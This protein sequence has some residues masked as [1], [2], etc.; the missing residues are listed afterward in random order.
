MN[1]IKYDMHVRKLIS[2]IAKKPDYW[3]L[4]Y[5]CEE[6]PDESCYALL[7]ESLKKLDVGVPFEYIIG[8][9]EFY[10][11]RF[12]VTENV[13]IPREE[14]EIL[15]E[16]SIILLTNSIKNN[17]KI[18]ELGVGSGAIISS[19]LLS[20]S[21]S[22]SATATDCSPEALSEARNNSIRLG[23]NIDF[24]LGDWWAA[25]DSDEEGPFDLIITNPPYV[26]TKKNNKGNTLSGYEPAISLYGKEPTPSG[27][28]DAMKIISG[29]SDWLEDDGRLLIEHGF[30]QRNMLSD[31][32]VSKGLVV[33][34][35]ID[36]LSGL[37]RVL[38]L[39]K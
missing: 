35:Q 17:L 28:K 18:L 5:Q 9:T 29:A 14:T 36:D 19:I 26:G 8:W 10:K 20:T 16:Q 4:A 2:H 12:Q 25:L 30:D 38:I 13:L 32:A 34:E 33:L 11:F 31:F 3:H 6:L 7:S 27:T 39:G 1:D 21:K 22:I 15:V 24:K 23:V 37:P